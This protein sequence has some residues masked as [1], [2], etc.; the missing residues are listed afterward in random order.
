MAV[1]VS[2]PGGSSTTIGPSFRSMISGAY[3]VSELSVKPTWIGLVSRTPNAPLG[4]TPI[5]AL[6]LKIAA[7]ETVG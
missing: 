2:G 5:L 1:Q 6:P 7:P 4:R 3:G